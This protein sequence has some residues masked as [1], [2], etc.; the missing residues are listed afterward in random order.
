M[1]PSAGWQPVK[2]QQQRSIWI[3]GLAVVEGKQELEKALLE[4]FGQSAAVEVIVFGK[5]GLELSSGGLRLS[6]KEMLQLEIVVQVSGLKFISRF[7][8]KIP[9]KAAILHW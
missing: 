8:E 7:C 5:A 2:I 3:C 9:V 6:W 4:R 1:M